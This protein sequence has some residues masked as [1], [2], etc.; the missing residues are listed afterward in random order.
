MLRVRGVKFGPLF[1]LVLIGD[2]RQLQVFTLTGILLL[3]V[4]KKDILQSKLLISQSNDSVNARASN[5]I[6]VKPYAHY[7]LSN[8]CFH[9]KIAL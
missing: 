8:F 2:A 3:E 9:Q 4:L 5:V 6:V 7:F 1:D